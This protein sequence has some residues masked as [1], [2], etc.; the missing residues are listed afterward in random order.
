MHQE[1]HTDEGPPLGGPLPP[2]GEPTGDDGQVDDLILSLVAGE[3]D[4]IRGALEEVAAA[5]C[6]D[7]R[8]VQTHGE[9]LQSI[10]E[11]A[12]RH[13]NIARLLRSRPMEGAID[14]ITLESLRNRMLD[15]V[16]DQLAR[17]AGADE[18]TIWT[19]F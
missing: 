5:F 6:S 8:I 11:L 19:S 15:G 3:L 10:D 14:M 7:I 12:Q 17:M 9:L 4:I 1:R 18:Q 13:E 2:C 16:T